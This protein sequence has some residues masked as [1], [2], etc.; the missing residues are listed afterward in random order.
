MHQGTKQGECFGQV[1][2]K[3]PI[4]YVSGNSKYAVG[5]KSLELKREVQVET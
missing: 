1:I 4:I 3:R 2:F 5:D